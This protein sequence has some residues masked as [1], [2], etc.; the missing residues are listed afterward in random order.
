MGSS[1]YQLLRVILFG[2]AVFSV[3]IT[4]SPT[5]QYNQAE[6]DEDIAGNS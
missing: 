6:R 4:L 2:W 3:S 5:Y 1:V